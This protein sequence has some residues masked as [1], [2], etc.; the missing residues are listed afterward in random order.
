[1]DIV[2]IAKDIVTITSAEMLKF[3]LFLLKW[4]YLA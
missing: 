4:A 2:T 3:R 1:M